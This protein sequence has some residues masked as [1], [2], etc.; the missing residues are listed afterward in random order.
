MYEAD[1]LV[2]RT[3]VD[4]GIPI[5]SNPGHP[6]VLANSDVIHIRLFCRKCITPVLH[7]PGGPNRNAV[8]AKPIAIPVSKM[9]LRTRPQRMTKDGDAHHLLVWGL[10]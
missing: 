1:D 5:G 3:G 9:K 8:Y 7:S 4:F 10:D 2:V 6:R